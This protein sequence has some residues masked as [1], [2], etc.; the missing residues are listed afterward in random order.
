M[1]GTTLVRL[2][3]DFRGD[4]WAECN[5]GNLLADSLVRALL[6]RSGDEWSQVRSPTGQ[7]PR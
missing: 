2:T 4:R 6:A 7:R 5:L 1:I 3:C